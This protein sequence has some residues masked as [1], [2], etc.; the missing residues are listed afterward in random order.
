MVEALGGWGKKAI[1]TIKRIGRLQGQ[2][3]GV[4]PAESTRHLF[5][6]LAVA[7]WK[8]NASLW[9]QRQPVRMTEVDRVV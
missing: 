4:E 9:T 5:Q 7:L 2:R 1:H 3:L 6:R 8:G